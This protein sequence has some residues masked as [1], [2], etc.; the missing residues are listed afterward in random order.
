[1]RF[2][3]ST[4]TISFVTTVVLLSLLSGFQVHCQAQDSPFI[5][6]QR[7]E[8]KQKSADEPFTIISLKE[9]G[10]ALIRGKNKYEE[11]KQ[12]WDVLLLD[13][14]LNEKHAFE[15][16][17]KERYPLIGYEYVGDD[18]FLLYRMGDFSRSAL[19]LIQL[20]LKGGN[21]K[22][23]FEIKPEL[24]FKITHFNKAGRTMVLGG[25]VNN[26]PAV[27]LY[28]LDDNQIKVVPGF[29][30]KDNELVELRVN[31]NQTF[32]I[33]MIDRSTRTDRK[34]VFRTFDESG[35]M[36]L[37]DIVPLG[38]NRML[39]TAIS[40]ALERDEL[41]VLGTWGDRQGRQAS[42]FFSLPVDPF[43]DQK[44]NYINFGEL[45]HFTDYLNSKRAARIKENANEAVA[46]DRIPSFSA[47]VMPFRVDEHKDGFLLLSEVYNAGSSPNSNY[48]SPYSPYGTNP[49]FNPMWPGYYPGMRVYRPYMYG[50]NV[51]NAEEIKT[52]SAVLTS[53]DATGKIKWDQSFKLDEVKKEAVE[54]V[55]DYYFDGANTYFAYIKESELHYKVIEENEGLVREGV[56]KLALL[57]PQDEKR[58]ERESDEGI[59]H[60]FGN[61]FYVWGYQTIRNV[62]KEDD[63]VRDVFFISKLTVE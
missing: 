60:W 8:Q 17:V 47:Y 40:S 53:F 55:S 38:D 21:E 22:A 28:S 1:M 36:L 34:L 11:N 61:T 57:E 50:N 7:Y 62:S 56:E 33:L 31:Q 25:Y 20:D 44:I 51:R 54:Q 30:Q 9:K 58:N 2:M 42:G 32:N 41:M 13:S 37:E 23:R 12:K 19:E 49:Y 14:A 35:K 26:D 45:K 63:R 16:L 59:R 15:I 3:E 39:Q 4:S 10:L 29:F 43:S 18:L 27:L 52:Q 6:Q 5:H 24:D 48:F 46:Q